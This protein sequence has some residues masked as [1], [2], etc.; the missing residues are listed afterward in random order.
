MRRLPATILLPR[1]GQ[2]HRKRRTALHTLTQTRSYD[3]CSY[4]RKP[5]GLI[6]NPLMCARLH[7]YHTTFP[8]QSIRERALRL[9]LARE[10]TCRLPTTNLFPKLG[11]L[12]H[13]ANASAF[14]PT[15]QF[16]FSL[17]H[18]AL[19]LAANPASQAVLYVFSL[20]RLTLRHQA[21]GYVDRAH[22]RDALLW[23]NTSCHQVLD[24]RP[25]SQT[26]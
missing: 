11:Q 9:I 19:P 4:A 21:W 26:P 18:L 20:N 12:P 17:L 8:A 23:Q 7:T 14:M 25:R 6:N 16:L 13:T 24:R 3:R 2:L 15:P 10:A 5:T 22:A 1:L